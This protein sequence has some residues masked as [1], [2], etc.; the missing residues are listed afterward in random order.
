MPSIGRR[1]DVLL[2]FALAVAAATQAP[3]ARAAGGPPVPEVVVDVEAIDAA[4]RVEA[5]IVEVTVYSDRARVRRRGRAAL[6]PGARVVR[7]PDLPGATFLDTVRLSASGARVLRVVAAPVERERLA[8]DQAKKL[9]DELDA[10]DDLLAEID[11]RSARDDWMASITSRLT[12][13]APV[14]EDKREG[15]KPLAVDVPSWIKALDFLGERVTAIRTRLVRI[16]DERRELVERRERVRADLAALNQGGLST[17]TVEVTAVLDVPGGGG[18]ADVQLEYFVPGARWKPAYDLHFTSARGQLRV[19]TSAMVEQATG[20]DWERATLHLSTA[21]PGRGIDLP[22]LLTWTLGE[23]SDFVPR[24]RPKPAAQ[25]PAPMVSGQPQ[26]P[27]ALPAKRAIEVEIVRERLARVTSVEG[28]LGKAGAPMAD[29]APEVSRPRVATGRRMAKKSYASGAPAAAPMDMAESEEAMPMPMLPMPASTMVVSRSSAESSRVPGTTVPLALF[30]TTP[31]RRPP[32]L[33]DPYLPAVSSGGLDYVYQA[34]TPATIP[35]T[36]QQIRIPLAGQTFSARVFH[37]ATPALA[38]TAF[39]RARVRNDGKRPLLRGPA[40]IFGD[41]ELVGVGEIKTTGPGGDV[42]FP[43]GADQDI[44][45]VRQIVPS[46]KTTGI[47]MKSEETVYD[48]QI[49][50]GNYKKQPATVEIIDQLP[51]SRKEKVEVKLLGTDPAP[52]GPADADGVLRWRVELPAGGTRTLRLRYQIVRPKD[53][54]L[55]QR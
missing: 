5:P 39:L 55:F 13:A 31:A 37:E 38:T 3:A 18:A 33:G 16:A 12:P 42:E 48:V 1:V 23:R 8:I 21:M 51:T 7:F 41:G 43:L 6:K 27:S 47:I 52:V 26:S 15:R 35:S 2:A 11:D 14:P 17:R 34:P 19:E 49:Q 30:D 9:L 45:L 50:V 54:V 46:S 28:E 25:P 22:E 20:E 40:T 29:L 36:G 24:P 4:P 32:P 44:R 10:V 53:W